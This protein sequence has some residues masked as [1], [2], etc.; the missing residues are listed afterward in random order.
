[1]LYATFKTQVI[2]VDNGE[3]LGMPCDLEF[4]EHYQIC[5][6]YVMSRP[7]GM[8]RLFPWFFHGEERM[9]RI[10]QIV[11]VGKDVILVSTC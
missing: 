11:R 3:L 4:D 8:K 5:M 6:L 2:S 10:S 9:V 7:S 1:M